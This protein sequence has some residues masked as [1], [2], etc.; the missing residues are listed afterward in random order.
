MEMSSFKSEYLAFKSDYL[1]L[2]M[3]LF[4]YRKSEGLS[5]RVLRKLP[6]LAHALYI[7][8]SFF[9]FYIFLV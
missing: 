5:G 3:S 7:Q 2:F 6:F 9:L 4:Y 8:V 1:A